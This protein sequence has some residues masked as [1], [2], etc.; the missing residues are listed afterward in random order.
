MLLAHAASCGHSESENHRAR[1]CTDGQQV[2]QTDTARTHEHTR[3]RARANIQPPTL[4]HTY[5]LALCGVRVACQAGGRCADGRRH[6]ETEGDGQEHAAPGTWP[7]TPSRSTAQL[8]YWRIYLS[9]ASSPEAR[10]E[11]C[12]RAERE[13]GPAHQIGEDAS[14]V[15]R[16]TRVNIR[17]ITV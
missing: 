17:H 15:G 8:C 4:A 16:R 9:L 2:S 10:G 12:G 14:T 11:S 3:A 5:I 13:P 1:T 6:R 7:H